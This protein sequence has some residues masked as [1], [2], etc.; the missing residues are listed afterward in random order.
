MAPARL[1]NPTARQIENAIIADVARRPAEDFT[2]QTTW[3]DLWTE[4][5]VKV[6]IDGIDLDI[7]MTFEYQADLYDFEMYNFYPSM[8]AIEQSNEVWTDHSYQEDGALT[9]EIAD[10]FY[11]DCDLDANDPD[12][13]TI[14]AVSTALGIIA[15]LDFGFIADGVIAANECSDII[16]PEY[17]YDYY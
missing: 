14:K 3:R 5:S 1:I 10:A 9:H 7:L 12:R 15:D 4:T 8:L 11:A 6:T 2:P 17:D 16:S 13:A